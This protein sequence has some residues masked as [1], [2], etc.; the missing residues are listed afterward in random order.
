M[1]ISWISVS[2]AIQTSNQRHDPHRSI[3][4]GQQKLLV[5]A[6]SQNLVLE[7]VYW[8]YQ[9]SRFDCLKQMHWEM[10]DLIHWLS[11]LT[12]KWI[13]ADVEEVEVDESK[14][15]GQAAYHSE[16]IPLRTLLE[17]ASWDTAAKCDDNPQVS[18]IMGKQPKIRKFHVSNRC[19]IVFSI[20][21]QG[22]T[23]KNDTTKNDIFNSWHLGVGGQEV[24]SSQGVGLQPLRCHQLD[25]LLEI[26]QKR[27]MKHFTSF[28]ILWKHIWKNQK[29][30][31]DLKQ[32]WRNLSKTIL[33][34]G[35][36]RW[37]TVFLENAYWIK[38][39]CLLY[40]VR[41]NVE[42]LLSLEATAFL[43]SHFY[44]G[45]F[46]SHTG[47]CGIALWLL[48]HLSGSSVCLLWLLG[49]RMVWCLDSGGNGAIHGESDFPTQFTQITKKRNKL[50]KINIPIQLEGSGPQLSLSKGNISSRRSSY[51]SKEI[52]CLW[53]FEMMR[54]H[55][56]S[57]GPGLTSWSPRLR[58]PF[59]KFKNLW[60]K[61]C[62]KLMTPQTQL[63]KC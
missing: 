54:S 1:W 5:L 14:W 2:F 57:L 23:W 18:K 60:N 28:D 27:Q 15:I 48:L 40:P 51:K 38:T 19:T 36:D 49:L 35:L 16:S 52:H 39:K 26:W 12:A 33:F 37:S 24:T 58:F 55:I 59:P 9:K 34:N 31:V 3:R 6:K 63:V 21:F 10:E 46:A 44:H 13:P 47:M 7:M 22:K 20:S 50:Y 61:T 30:T 41:K 56:S 11:L 32:N 17:P 29:N 4:S 53:F 45:S 25:D 8:A 42:K 62:K 43:W